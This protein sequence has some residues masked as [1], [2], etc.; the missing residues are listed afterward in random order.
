MDYQKATSFEVVFFCLL[1]LLT[2]NI[3]RN[4]TQKY[5]DSLRVLLIEYFRF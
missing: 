5:S 3:L 2:A 1:L 4:C